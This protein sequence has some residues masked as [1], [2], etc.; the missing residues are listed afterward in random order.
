MRGG[1]LANIVLP[2]STTNLPAFDRI[3][4][5]AELRGRQVRHGLSGPIVRADSVAPGTNGTT[6]VD[7]SRR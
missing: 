7:R 2:V 1:R 5:D 3:L 4:S 6:C